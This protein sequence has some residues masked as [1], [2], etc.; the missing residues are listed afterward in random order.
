[1]WKPNLVVS[2]VVP[3]VLCLISKGAWRQPLLD[4]LREGDMLLGVRMRVR[5]GQDHG[6]VAVAFWAKTKLTNPGN[7]GC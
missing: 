4:V 3:G 7:T 6:G 1:M 5:G 2:E